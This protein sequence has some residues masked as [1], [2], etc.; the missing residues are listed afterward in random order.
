MRIALTG[1]PVCNQPLD[2]VGLCYAID[3]QPP[4]FQ[5]KAFWSK[6]ANGKTINQATV[7]AFQRFCDRVK[8]SILDLPPMTQEIVNFEAELPTQVVEKYNDGQ[9][10]ND[11]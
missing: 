10:I 1:T 7:K 2:M 4:S 5:Q 3:L 6:D 11:T 9:T 8:D